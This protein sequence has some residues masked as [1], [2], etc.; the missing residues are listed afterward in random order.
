MSILRSFA[1][2]CT[3]E[4]RE[5]ACNAGSAS[6]ALRSVGG[7]VVLIPGL[8]PSPHELCKHIRGVAGGFGK[9]FSAQRALRCLW[10]KHFA[11]SIETSTRFCSTMIDVP[12]DSSPRC[13]NGHRK[14]GPGGRCRQCKR[15]ADLRY[16]HSEKGRG[17][18]AVYEQGEAGKARKARFRSTE[19][20][21]EGCARYDHSEKGLA[22]KARYGQTDKGIA[23]R[24]RFRHSEKGLASEARQRHG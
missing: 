1:Y 4:R 22:R 20:G 14:P 9:G 18:R 8:H 10:C 13:R 19:K 21:Q 7:G 23:T 3:E 6:S 15:D 2:G 11:T 24:T 12:H 5:A 16:R 17:Q